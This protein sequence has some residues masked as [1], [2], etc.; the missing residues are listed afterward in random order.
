MIK[1]KGDRQGSLPSQL[2]DLINALLLKVKIEGEVNQQIEKH[3]GSASSYKTMTEQRLE[4]P[5]S[6]GD[7]Y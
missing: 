1:I 7:I 2:R 3:S 6:I 5:C 4:H